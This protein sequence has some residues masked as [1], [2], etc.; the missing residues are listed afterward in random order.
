MGWR[1]RPGITI[2]KGVRLRFGKQGTSVTYRRRG[3][4]LTR[5]PRGTRANFNLPGTG[6]TYQYELDRTRPPR[7][8][9]ARG[10][11]TRGVGRRSSKK[12]VV[13]L[14]VV[15]LVIVG[16][17]ATPK[18][19]IVLTFIMLA[20]HGVRS[21]LLRERQRAM[22]LQGEVP[23]TLHVADIS[24]TELAAMGEYNT[25]SV[26]ESETL[27]A[28]LERFD[29][30]MSWKRYEDP[31]W[32]E[33]VLSEVAMWKALAR[34]VERKSPPPLLAEAHRAKRA[35]LVAYSDAAVAIMRWLHAAE[36]DSR[37]TSLRV[38]EE[39]LVRAT[40]LTQDCIQLTNELTQFFARRREGGRRVGIK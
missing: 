20:V 6:I 29:I 28:S 39:Q 25:W 19:T 27:A 34:E 18:A 9:A 23:A 26:Y 35:A 37:A 38:A 40:A 13:V 1:F 11:S 8:N 30:L 3:F 4:S 24:D 10:E 15:G 17:V 31:A 32:R 14:L 33:D 12:Y 2:A 7:P 5:G 22:L 36:P 21:V 16:L